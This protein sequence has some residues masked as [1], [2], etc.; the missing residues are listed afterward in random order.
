MVPSSVSLVSFVDSRLGSDRERLLAQAREFECIAKAA[1]LTELDLDAQFVQRFRAV[2]R[3]RVRGFGFYSWKPQVIR[4]SLRAL[5]DGSLLVYVDGGS[6]LNSAGEGRFKDYLEQCHSSESG[7]LAFQTHWTERHWTKGDL[8]DHFAVR[9]NPL[10][11][12]TGQV[13][14]GFLLLRNTPKTRAFVD[15]WAKVFWDNFSLVDDT[16]S[17]SPNLEGFIEHR[18][19]QSIFSLLAKLRGIEVLS[20]DEQEPSSGASRQLEAMPVVHARDIAS[21]AY[22]LKSRMRRIR[23]LKDLALVRVK[24]RGLRFLGLNK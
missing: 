10:V 24:K 17:R 1:V 8:L 21:R 20:A 22:T 9:D 13:Q 7:I 23:E 15:S 2:L 4:Q 11:T 12:E 19:D 14:A 3:K 6:H 5:P 18:H 16:P